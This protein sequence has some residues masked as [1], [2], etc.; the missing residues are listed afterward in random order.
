MKRYSYM[1]IYKFLYTGFEI[2]YVINLKNLYLCYSTY[3]GHSEQ[4]SEI[5]PYRLTIHDTDNYRIL[6][7]Y[8]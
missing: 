8:I 4:S 5:V 1:I 6:Y 3:A 2:E 7:E